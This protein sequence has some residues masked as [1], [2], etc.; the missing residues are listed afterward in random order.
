MMST[1]KNTTWYSEK[2]LENGD[3]ESILTLGSNRNARIVSFKINKEKKEEYYR[4]DF[5]YNYLN[6]E[7][8]LVLFFE[9]DTDAKINGLMISENQ[10]W[11][12]IRR[13][14]NISVLPIIDTN[15]NFTKQN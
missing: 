2:K 4:I 5:G 15:F 13:K 9:D 14:T 7:Q 8:E 6:K 10:M 11:I 12:S 1:L 3:P